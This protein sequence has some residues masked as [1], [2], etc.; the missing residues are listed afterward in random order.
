MQTAFIEF[1]EDCGRPGGLG[2]CFAQ[3]GIQVDGGIWGLL[4]GLALLIGCLTYV[5]VLVR[6]AWHD[7]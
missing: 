2:I 7:S 1:V 4:I 6:R 5:V 3:D